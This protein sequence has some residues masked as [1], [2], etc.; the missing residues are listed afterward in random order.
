M[1]GTYHLLEQRILSAKSMED[2]GILFA[3]NCAD[4]VRDYENE[5]VQILLLPLRSTAEVRGRVRRS[6]N[7]MPGLQAR[8]PHPQSAAGHGLHPGRPRI[9]PDVGYISAEVTRP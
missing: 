1:E 2:V 8:H 6:A 9:R 4:A 5:R 7:P 3:A